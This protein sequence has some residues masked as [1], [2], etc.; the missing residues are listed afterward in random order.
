MINCE[1]GSKVIVVREEGF[2]NALTEIVSTLAEITID[3]KIVFLKASTSIVVTLGSKEFQGS[4]VIV[5]FLSQPNSFIDYFVSS[6]WKYGLSGPKLS[7]SKPQEL[8]ATNGDV[9]KVINPPFNNFYT[10]LWY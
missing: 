8:S 1:L 7:S 4:R 6:V 5:S 2:W 9:V 3:F 10:L